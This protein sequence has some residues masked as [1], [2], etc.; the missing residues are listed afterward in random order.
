MKPLQ[1]DMKPENYKSQIF[2]HLPYSSRK[3][4]RNSNYKKAKVGN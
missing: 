2:V 4:Q 1:P 3:H